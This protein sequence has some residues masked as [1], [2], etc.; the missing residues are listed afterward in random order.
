MSLM[1]A[2]AEPGCPALVPRGRC[3]AHSR[4]RWAGRQARL[5]HSAARGYGAAWRRLRAQVGREEGTCRLCGAPSTPWICD[6]IVPKVQGGTDDRSNLQRLC[7]PCSDAKSAREG[8][9]TRYTP[10]RRVG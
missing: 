9:A 3:A 10:P 1:R 6:H 8:G 5:G 2:C 7:Q 4:E